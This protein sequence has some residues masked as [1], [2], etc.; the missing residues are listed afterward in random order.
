MLKK[1]KN[2]FDRDRTGTITLENFCDVLGLK[3]AEV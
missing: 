3:A 2:L 1:W